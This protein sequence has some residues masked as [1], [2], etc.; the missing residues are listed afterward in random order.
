MDKT[1][2]D[3][4]VSPITRNMYIVLVATRQYK[5]FYAGKKQYRFYQANCATGI[6]IEEWTA[7][8]NQCIDKK[9]LNKRGALTN[10]GK[11]H[12]GDFSITVNNI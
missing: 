5:S 11:Y 12:A 10:K 2:N 8:K 9:L 4:A 6:T 7:A 3:Y 1:L